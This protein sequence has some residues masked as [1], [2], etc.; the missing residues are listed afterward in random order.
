[1]DRIE[2]G[3]TRY[4]GLSRIPR[5]ELTKDF[6]M[7]LPE[8]KLLISNLFEQKHKPILSEKVV[9]FK[10]R[11]EQWDRVCSSN[12]SKKPCLVFDSVLESENFLSLLRKRFN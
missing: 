1:M 3:T 11:K 4:I 7:N 5:Y 9:G 2:T 6:F 10:G 12:A 8:G